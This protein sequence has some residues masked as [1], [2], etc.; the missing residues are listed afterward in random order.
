MIKLE[1]VGFELL[2][3]KTREDFDKIF[4]EHSPR[5]ERKLKNVESCRIMLKEYGQGRRTKFSIH[6]LVNY[7]GKTLEADATDW[8]LRKTV[9]KAFNKIEEEI[10]HVFHVS[11][12]NRRKK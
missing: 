10:E 12:Q 2:N 5:I 3:E 11:D 6:I 4:E 7:S 1:K 8:D 9:R